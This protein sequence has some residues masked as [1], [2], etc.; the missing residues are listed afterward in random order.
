MF[1]G[2]GFV[3]VVQLER[4]VAELE[5]VPTKSKTCDQLVMEQ[6]KGGREDIRFAAHSCAMGT[7]PAVI[8]TPTVYLSGK[9]LGG[10]SSSG[11]WTSNQ[12]AQFTHD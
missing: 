6:R 1:R 2:K 7:L 5:R 10:K 12:S 8:D 9:N 11:T 4:S 3:A